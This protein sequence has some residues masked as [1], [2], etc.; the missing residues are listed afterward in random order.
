LPCLD[1]WDK[2]GLSRK[3]GICTMQRAF[4]TKATRAADGRWRANFAE[5]QQKEARQC[6]QNRLFPPFFF[7]FSR[8]IHL[9]HWVPALRS[10]HPHTLRPPHAPDD[11]LDAALTQSGVFSAIKETG[12]D[13]Q[14]CTL[15]SSQ[16]N[17]KAVQ[18]EVQ[19][20]LLSLH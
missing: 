6:R 3:T 19:L 10:P 16:M 7:V 2:G 1:V 4:F 14:H 11:A 9:C 17:H 12:L 20:H 8:L 15:H 13:Y 5:V 18:L